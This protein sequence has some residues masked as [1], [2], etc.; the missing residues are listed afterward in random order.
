MYINPIGVTIRRPLE[1]D[2]LYRQ[3]TDNKQEHGRAGGLHA[4]LP[5]R[6][7]KLQADRETHAQLG[8]PMASRKRFH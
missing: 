4:R 5:R 1:N 2:S 8:A 6:D 3:K 7:T